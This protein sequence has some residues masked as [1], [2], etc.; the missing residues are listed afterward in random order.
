[1]RPLKGW[2]AT[3]DQAKSRRIN[4]NIDLATEDP[5]AEIIINVPSTQARV[6]EDDYGMMYAVN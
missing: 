2:E 1:M 5:E 3:D 6:V 4:E